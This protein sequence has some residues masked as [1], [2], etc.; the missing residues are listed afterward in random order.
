MAGKKRLKKEIKQLRKRVKK[1]MERNLK[2]QEELSRL[3]KRIATRDAQGTAAPD[4][5]EPAAREVVESGS[6][7]G[8][9]EESLAA[10][11]RASWK[12]HTYLRDRYEAHL[13]K[14]RKKTDARR[15]AN[16]DLVAKY[17]EEAGFA[18]QDLQD[19]LT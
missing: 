9:L 13:N 6:L 18:E 15:F 4:L 19:I 17:G 2:A 11:H 12:R 3:Q 7:D 1:A 14:G 8:A 10:D 16:A 5:T